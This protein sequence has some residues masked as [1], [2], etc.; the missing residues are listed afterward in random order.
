MKLVI[1]SGLSGSGKSVALDALEDLGF[2][3][4]DNLP[5]GLLPAFAKQIVESPRRNYE[6][7]AVGIDARNLSDDFQGFPDLLDEITHMGLA[8]EVIF[9]Q[10]DDDTLIKRFS[11]TR[12][13]HPLTRAEVSL[14]EA[15]QME[16][17]VLDSLALSSAWCIDTTST[18]VHQLRDM[19]RGRMQHKAK[20]LSLTF[21][22]FG[23]KHGVPVDADYV[24]DIRCLPNPHWVPQLRALT[25]LDDEVREFLG[26]EADMSEMFDNLRDFLERWIP[27]FEADNR[28]Y[29]TVAIGCTGGQHRSVYLSRRLG[30]Y[31]SQQREGVLVRHRELS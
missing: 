15:I 10:A 24:F 14:P 21:L 9:L 20:S 30:D 3:C 23:Y 6:H 18:N 29:M 27:H 17:Q 11:E 22:S 13:K 26:Q 31:F 28:T 4:I 19:I 1:V 25:G 16:R 2:Y 5:L 7:A 8:C 12:R